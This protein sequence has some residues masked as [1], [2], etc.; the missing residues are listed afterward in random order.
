MPPLLKRFL[1]FW[2]SYEVL[3]RNYGNFLLY[4]FIRAHQRY[5]PQT[6]PQRTYASFPPIIETHI[7]PRFGTAIGLFKSALL[8]SSLQ[9]VGHLRFSSLLETGKVAQCHVRR[10]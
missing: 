2:G 8:I 10:R 1:G 9:K 5:P 3:Q 6:K 4:L 7:E